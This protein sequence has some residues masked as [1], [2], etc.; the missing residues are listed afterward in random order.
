MIYYR[1]EIQLLGAQFAYLLPFLQQ[2]LDFRQQSI[3]YVF[4]SAT[5]GGVD[6]KAGNYKVY[7]KQESVGASW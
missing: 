2:N 3:I 1:S 5:G 4:V 7:F 6:K